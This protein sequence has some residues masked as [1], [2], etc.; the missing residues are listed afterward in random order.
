[1]TYNSDMPV[2]SNGPTGLPTYRYTELPDGTSALTVEFFRRTGYSNNP[3][4]NYTVSFS[5]DLDAWESI[6]Q[7]HPNVETQELRIGWERVI[8]RDI[9][10]SQ[11]WTP[12]FGKLDVSVADEN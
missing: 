11:S 12:R 8:V 2:P 9:R 4:L 7:D 3:P 5:S 10:S 1:M 6:P